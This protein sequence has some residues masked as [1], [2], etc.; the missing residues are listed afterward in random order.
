MPSASAK[1]LKQCGKYHI[2]IQ[3][4]EPR[5]FHE[6]QNSSE[7]QQ[8]RRSTMFNLS[9]LSRLLVAG[10]LVVVGAFGLAARAEGPE[11]NPGT[12]KANEAI[13]ETVGN[14]RFIAFYEPGDGNCG[15]NVVMWPTADESGNSSTRV[16]V[17]LEANQAAYIDSSDNKSIKLQC[18]DLADT[19]RVIDDTLVASE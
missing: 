10:C 16:R 17:N 7:P 11:Q 19:L 15:L 5:S 4:G 14:Q 3:C 8:L 12:V 2:E 13:L 9:E 1:K 6:P 18:G